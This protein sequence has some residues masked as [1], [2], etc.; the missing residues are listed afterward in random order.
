ML[1]ISRNRL[2]PIVGFLVSVL[3]FSWAFNNFDY[4]QFK[5][6]YLSISQ[7]YVFFSL[8]ILLLSIWVRALRWQFILNDFD[9]IKTF[10]L[11]RFQLI[12]IFGNYIFPMKSGEL[13]RAYISS[14]ELNRSKNYIFGT[15][16]TERIIDGLFI[17][18]LA[19]VLFSMFGYNFSSKSIFILLLAIVFILLFAW[20][21]RKKKNQFEIV[22]GMNSSYQ[23]GFN[24]LIILTIFIW[25]LVIV[26]IW[27]ISMAFS[28]KMNLLSI[29]VILCAI[30]LGF[31]IPS[32][33]PGNL[34]IVHS[35]I[36]SPM[37]LMGYEESQSIAFAIILHAHGFI[38]FTVLGGLCML[39]S[40]IYKWNK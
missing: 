20:A 39:L 35:A 29:L 30:T 31:S 38:L 6:H 5:I 1:L 17:I 12:G 19:F 32:P 37:I 34:G 10:S 9:N 14:R 23:S 21:C 18:V 13:L 28:M 40:S 2:F 11:F 27:F 16:I 7:K 15:I 33:I 8:F 4:E 26:D 36:I 3:G 22:K 24:K 25:F